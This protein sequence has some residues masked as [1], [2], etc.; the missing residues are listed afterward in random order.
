MVAE[1]KAKG[2]Y[3]STLI[4]VSAKHGQ[5]PVDRSRLHMEP[6]GQ[7]T[8][9]VVDPLPSINTV[10]P[11]VDQVFSTFVNPNSG[12]MYAADG[13]LQTDDVGLVWLQNQSA[14]NIAGVVAALQGNAVAI[15]ASVLS[16][17][18]IFTS[19]IT[20]G[21][22]LAAIF[23]DPTSGDPLAAAPQRNKEG[24]RR[25]ARDVFSPPRL[26]AFLCSRLPAHPD[27][28]DWRKDQGSLEIAGAGSGG[29]D[30]SDYGPPRASSVEST[31]A[32]RRRGSPR[33]HGKRH[34][35]EA[36]WPT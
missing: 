25:G 20:S 31:E 21:A 14:A 13:H 11:N 2:L 1:L 27:F 18:T 6:G 16:P 26:L 33:R 35:R 12:N 36:A 23:G 5:S 7:G 9:D 17:G 3:D 8:A 34:D 10:D 19:N 29:A 32:R 15:E 28:G 24:R 22:A 4:I 30:N